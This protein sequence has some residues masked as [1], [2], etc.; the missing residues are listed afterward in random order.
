ALERGELVELLAR[1]GDAAFD[2]RTRIGESGAG[3]REPD[4]RVVDA[5]LVDNALG[6][7]LLEAIEAA[8]DDAVAVGRELRLQR[9]LRGE[10]E[11]ARGRHAQR[12]GRPAHLQAALSEAL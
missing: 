11:D 2:E 4:G 3:F 12:I 6:E 7:R 5:A 1:E 10:R 8:A 9:L